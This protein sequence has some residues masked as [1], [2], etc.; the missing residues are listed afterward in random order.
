MKNLQG[1]PEVPRGLEKTKFTHFV[2]DFRLWSQFARI[3]IIPIPPVPKGPL[4]SHRVFHYPPRPLLCLV[5]GFPEN[6]PVG[7]FSRLLPPTFERIPHPT[8]T[9]AGILVVVFFLL[10]FARTTSVRC[11][12]Q[13]QY[14]AMQ[15]CSLLQILTHI[16]HTVPFTQNKTSWTTP[17]FAER[18]PPK[19]TPAVDP[20]EDG[21]NLAGNLDHRQVA[22]IRTEL[23]AAYRPGRQPRRG[24]VQ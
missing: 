19:W 22:H 6:S 2:L 1:R 23:A 13:S 21:R 11:S 18:P 5:I 20:Y 24:D 9:F 14:N 4:F 12:A 7:L 8:T 3:P 15:L 17:S 10:Q 16:L